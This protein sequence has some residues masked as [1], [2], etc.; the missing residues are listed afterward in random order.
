[1]S[2]PTMLDAEDKARPNGL[3]LGHCFQAEGGPV[4]PFRQGTTGTE[5]YL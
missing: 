5:D 3:S 1:M 2:V 4:I